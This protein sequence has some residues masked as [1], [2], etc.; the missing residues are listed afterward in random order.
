MLGEVSTCP[1]FQP[2]SG[3]VG[4]ARLSPASTQHTEQFGL[5]RGWKETLM[6]WS[7]LSK[8]VL[9]AWET[10][11]KKRTK[12]TQFESHSGLRQEGGGSWSKE[13]GLGLA[14]LYHPLTGKSE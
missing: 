11:A 12:D 6:G 13:Y 2:P 10:Q 9:L 5:V 4:S 3:T 1:A 7:G 14:Q 8:V